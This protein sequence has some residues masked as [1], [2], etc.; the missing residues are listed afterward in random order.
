MGR[1]WPS[2]GYLS[3]SRKPL[4]SPPGSL[5]VPWP[6]ASGPPTLSLPSATC[7]W[8]RDA[9]TIQLCNYDESVATTCRTVTQ[10]TR[11]IHLSSVCHVPLAILHS[12]QFH[13][14]SFTALTSR[15]AC[16]RSHEQTNGPDRIT[17]VDGRRG[18]R[19]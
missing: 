8:L 14:N 18:P 9:S 19:T 10:L 2:F 5:F 6:P 3:A 15:L 1:F 12:R 13:G 17:Q 4:T 11:T 16:L 7:R